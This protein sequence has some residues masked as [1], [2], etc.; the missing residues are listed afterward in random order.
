MSASAEGVV[1]SAE[2]LSGMAAEMLE[3]IGMFKLK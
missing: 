1:K 3:I 2:D